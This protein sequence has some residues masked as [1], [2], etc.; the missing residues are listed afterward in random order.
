MSRQSRPGAGR[1]SVTLAVAIAAA[2]AVTLLALWSAAQALLLFF[3]AVLLATLLR[4]ASHALASRTR[5][6]DGWS[7]AIVLVA[8]A[9]LLS[10]AGFWMAPT[11]TGQLQEF[12]RQLPA[13]VEHAEQALE[14]A[15]FGAG[16]LTGSGGMLERL[17][18]SDE[19]AEQAAR[20]LAWIPQLT[21]SLL[22]LIFV[23]IYFAIQPA[24]YLDGLVRLLP[25]GW[26]GRASVILDEV[27]HTLRWWLITRVVS[28]AAVG[29]L[30][31]LMLWLLGLPLAVLLGLQ[32][33][34]LTFVPY[35]G[36]I[37]AT[38]P[39]AIVAMTEP[40]TLF[41]AIALYTII[42]SVEGF[43]ITPLA[44][45]RLV[46]LPPALTLISEVVMGVW[47][48]VIGVVFATPLAAALLPVTRRLY[49]EDT[50]HEPVDGDGAGRRSD[51]RA[52]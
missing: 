33:F 2:A 24:L 1:K 22:I 32:A 21:G 5:L 13:A 4:S 9:G 43:L 31:T 45:E 48:G 47:F 35:I 12:A 6:S 27:A 25:P 8:L 39:I 3:G 42:Q 44:Q 52:A 37:L 20:A 10:G 50:L 49:L 17:Q 51:H 46:Y 30:T 38:I 7:L 16:L 23:G 26:R 40:H 29:A 14:R 28:M 41:P 19:L 11:V 34:L 18:D 15:G 36:P